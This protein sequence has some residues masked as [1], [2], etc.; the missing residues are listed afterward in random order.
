MQERNEMAPS[1][2]WVLL[3]G[4]V[5]SA[6]ART[7]V[8]PLAGNTYQITV[9]AARF[10]G[11]AGAEKLASH[12]A[13]LATLQ[14]GFDSYMIL[15]G[16]AQDNVGVVGYTPVIANTYDTATAYGSP[17]MATAYGSSTTSYSGGTPIIAGTHDQEIVVRMFHSG[18]PDAENAIPARAMLGPDWQEAVAKGF[19][20]TCT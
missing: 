17:G 5:V 1:G 3:A 8:M 20:R 15:D 16:Q 4:L 14:S 18:D 11:A 19:P 7:S 12:D 9:S 13:A 6:C 2:K 10:C